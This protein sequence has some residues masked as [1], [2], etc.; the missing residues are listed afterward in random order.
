L[1]FL[2][3]CSS[4]P[5]GISLLSILKDY[6]RELVFWTAVHQISRSLS[7][8][9]VHAHIKGT[10]SLKAETARGIVQLWR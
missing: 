9:L 7:D 5:P 2:H 6:V 4:N 10:F 8:R 3:D 1:P